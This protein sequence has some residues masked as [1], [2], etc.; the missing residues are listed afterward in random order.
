[1]LSVMIRVSSQYQSSPRW[2]RSSVTGSARAL[3]RR[4]DIDVRQ[5]VDERRSRDTTVA[6]TLTSNA[7]PVARPSSLPIGVWPIRDRKSVVEGK[8][9]SVRVDLGGCGI[10]KKKKKK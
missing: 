7:S 3:V 9:V 4:Y 2:V 10:V 5:T 8:S 1:M 6:C